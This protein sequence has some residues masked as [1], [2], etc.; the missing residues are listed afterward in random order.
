M[1]HEIVVLNERDQLLLADALIE[2]PEAMTGIHRLR[3]GIARAYIV[4]TP[5]RPDVAVVQSRFLMEEPAAYG[6]DPGLIWDVLKRVPGWTA[7]NAEREV[8]PKLAALI[9]AETGKTCLLIEEIYYTLNR[10][11]SMFSNP[12]VRRIGLD[13]LA[14]VEAAT[15]PLS[16]HGWR[17][18]TAEALLTHGLLFG[19]VVDG[20]LVSVAFSASGSSKYS[21]VGIKTR[22][23]FRGRGYSTAAASLICAEI[24]ARGQTAVWSTDQDNIAS[25]RVAA[26]LGFQEVSRR[27]YV[28][29]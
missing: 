19:A 2:T 25:Q 27:I 5:E 8:A 6:G 23:D 1:T 4:G 13:D 26:K 3:R 24:Q 21:E 11:V 7:V 14:M 9:E 10:P 15:E 20:E 17:F 12:A 28:N 29:R 18:G 16:M 22:E